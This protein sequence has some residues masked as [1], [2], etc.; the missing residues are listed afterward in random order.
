MS[1][2]SKPTEYASLDGELAPA[3]ET[4]LPVSDGG[5]LRGDGIFEV[6]KLYEGRPFTLGPHLDRLERSGEAMR[7][8]VERESLE[9]EIERVLDAR[10]ESSG[11]L[12]IVVTREGR[13]LA[14]TE[15]PLDL[16]RT[17][18]LGLVTY[19]PDQV[20]DGVKSLSYGGNWLATR[21]AKER[22]FDDAI[23]V[24]ESGEV[25]EAPT[26]ALFWVTDGELRTTPLELG[27]LASVTRKVII[28]TCPVTEAVCSVEELLD[29][30]EAFLASV[31]RE[32][33]P[34]EAIED[35][36]FSAPGPITAATRAAFW[37]AVEAEL[38]IDVSRPTDQSASAA[39][40]G[41]VP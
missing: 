9:R 10:G 5:F 24:K 21:L 36:G 27:I 16:P 19:E 8:E 12:R 26:S 3:A 14:M 29:A 23:L 11:L 15:P 37:K 38:G 41:D 40:G 13:H 4:A 6:I 17:L 28:E 1:N 34:V 20:L 30:D 33:H 31:S 25:L 35:S 7:I 39:G 2:S 32:V 22:G 18:R